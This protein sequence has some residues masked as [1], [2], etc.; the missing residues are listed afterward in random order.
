[1][2]S[3]VINLDTATSRWNN[4]KEEFEK[5]DLQP[6]RLSAVNGRDLSA[7]QRKKHATFACSLFCADAVLGTTLSHKSAW[8]IAANEEEPVLICEDDV[9]FADEFKVRLEECMRELPE[10]WD[11]LYLGCLFCEKNISILARAALSLY[12][13][14]NT[15][16]RT[17]SARLWISPYTFGAHSYVVSSKG[18]RKLI[19]LFDKVEGSVDVR[20]NDLVSSGLLHAYV[21]KILLARQKVSSD[22]SSIAEKVPRVLNRK[23]DNILLAPDVS[24]AYGLS[25]PLGKIGGFTVNAWSALFFVLGIVGGSLGTTI[26]AALIAVD[27]FQ[28][29][30]TVLSAS[31]A[32]AVG[33]LV[34]LRFRKTPLK[35]RR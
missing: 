15:R 1:M 29:D 8:E 3:L 10:G 19:S 16:S 24:L 2:K 20:M 7:L 31:A 5:A 22:V 32:F 21:P 27:V 6:I 35:T 11:I 17:V 34:G 33:L 26:F 4:V 25:Y 9:K 12:A 28:R 30:E 14:K 18:A 13:L 23:L